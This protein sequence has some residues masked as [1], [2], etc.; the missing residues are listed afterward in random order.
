MHIQ[1]SIQILSETLSIYGFGNELVQSDF[2]CLFV[3]SVFVALVEI[4]SMDWIDI[5]FY[6]YILG[7]FWLL[8]EIIFEFYLFFI[9]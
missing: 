6:G 8:D 4:V 3:G 2:G 1:F 7:W 5:W 9:H